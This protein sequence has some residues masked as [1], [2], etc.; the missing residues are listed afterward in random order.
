MIESLINDVVQQFINAPPRDENPDHD[1]NDLVHP[2][3]AYQCARK[4]YYNMHSSREGTSSMPLITGTLIHAYISEK[5]NGKIIDYKRDD[6]DI[7]SEYD[8]IQSDVPIDLRPK[9]PIIGVADLVSDNEVAD[10]KTTSSSGLFFRKREGKASMGH[11]IQTGIYAL[12]LGKPK[13]VV[14]YISR[15]KFNTLA[16]TYNLDDYLDR[17]YAEM[18][19]LAFIRTFPYRP[20]REMPDGRTLN[21]LVDWECRYCNFRG[22]CLKGENE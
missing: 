21:P 10:L 8:T 4:V 2:N 16:Y 6:P 11:I 9:Y 19:R 1:E 12:A 17:I 18:E 7:S 13:I 15:E 14:I 3:M 5:L 22:K 20:N